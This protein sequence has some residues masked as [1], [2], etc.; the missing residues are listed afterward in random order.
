MIPKKTHRHTQSFYLQE[1]NISRIMP[2]NK[3]LDNQSV[4]DP[5]L[6]ES[7]K[8]IQQESRLPFQKYMSMKENFNYGYLNRANPPVRP[9][10]AHPQSKENNFLAPPKKTPV[11][12]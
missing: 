1:N 7:R 10:F 5:S 11:V 12:R 3:G 2:K 9:V 8:T 4:Q 6:N